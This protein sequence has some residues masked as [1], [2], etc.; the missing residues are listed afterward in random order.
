MPYEKIWILLEK[1]RLHLSQDTARKFSC[2]RI[3][4]ASTGWTQNKS[5]NF[6]ILL[7]GFLIRGWCSSTLSA[8][9]RISR[10]W[11]VRQQIGYTKL[12][13]RHLD[14]FTWAQTRETSSHI[15]ASSMLY[16]EIKE[17]LGPSC[18]VAVTFWGGWHIPGSLYHIC[19]SHE[20]LSSV[21]C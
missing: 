11:C 12:H 1:K 5:P 21:F 2:D 8:V 4:V 13:S 7:S 15:K 14:G 9:R 3:L 19:F 20:P 10:E 6:A 17:N 16:G 18:S